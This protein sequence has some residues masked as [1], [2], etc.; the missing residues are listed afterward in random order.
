MPDADCNSNPKHLLLSSNTSCAQKL[1]IDHL[2]DD[3][4][5]HFTYETIAL[6]N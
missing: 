5:H 4:F 2:Q 1:K 6:S 3:A